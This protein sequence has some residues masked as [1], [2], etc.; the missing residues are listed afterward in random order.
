MA[1]N[2]NLGAVAFQWIVE[3][4]NEIIHLIRHGFTLGDGESIQ[5]PGGLSYLS[6]GLAVLAALF[7]SALTY[8]RQ[9][10]EANNNNRSRLASDV[11]NEALS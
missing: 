8:H 1:I 5:L 11:S 7:L 4:R 10:K 3:Y 6:L 2:F 9:G